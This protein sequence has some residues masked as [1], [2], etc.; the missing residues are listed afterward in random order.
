MIAPCW[1]TSR[2]A[3]TAPMPAAEAPTI[4]YFA[5][6]SFDLFEH[7]TLHWD[8]SPRK[9]GLKAMARSH[10]ATTCPSLSIFMAPYGQTM[11]QVQQPMH[12]SGLCVTRPVFSSFCIAPVRQA[13]RMGHLRSVGIGWRRRRACLLPV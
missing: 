13:L 7:L 6:Y 10:L 12:F 4:T 2:M 8:S 11:T 1:S 9:L 5:I 3:S